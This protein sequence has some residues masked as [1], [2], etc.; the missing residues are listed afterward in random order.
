MNPAQVPDLHNFLMRKMAWDML[1]HDERA[2]TVMEGLNLI[3][4]STDVVEVEMRESHLRTAKLAP[5]G[6]LVST[7]ASMATAIFGASMMS[8]RTDVSPETAQVYMQMTFDMVRVASFAIIGM[9]METDALRL[10]M[11][12]VQHSG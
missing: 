10:G 6:D 3:P 12:Q 1:P 4:A 9:L 5:I 2:L 7:Y 8:H 11:N